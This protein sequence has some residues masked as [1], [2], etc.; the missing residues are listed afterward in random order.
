[1]LKQYLAVLFILLLASTAF[2]GQRFEEFYGDVVWSKLTGFSGYDSYKSG[3]RDKQVD[4]FLN[5]KNEWSDTHGTDLPYQY[6][7]QGFSAGVGGRYWFP[8]NKFFGTVSVGEGV[9]GKNTGRFDFR[10]GFAGYNAWQQQQR[11]TD[12]YGE[13]FWVG[14]AGDS[15]LNLRFRPGKIVHQ[16][17]TGR[18]WLY[19]VGQLWAS[20]TGSNG[21]ENRVE[22]GIGAGYTYAGMFSV[23]LELRGGD[24][25]RGT[26]THRTYFNP[27]VVISG[28]F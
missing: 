4:Y 13:L 6:Q 2:A 7:I 24:A 20:G 25:F 3:I 12:L 1:M 22:A 16:D 10:T 26:I 28:G 21:T 27:T 18:L 11:F 5:I 19:G 9:S 8:G 23:N 14:L 17:E 15:Y